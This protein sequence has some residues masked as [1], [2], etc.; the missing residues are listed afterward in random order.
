[1]KNIYRAVILQFQFEVFK[2]WRFA[3]GGRFLK[4]HF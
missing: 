3:G 4:T 2:T 1:M